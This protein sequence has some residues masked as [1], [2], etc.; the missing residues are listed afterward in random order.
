MYY[1]CLEDFARSMLLGMVAIRHRVNCKYKLVYVHKSQ[2]V[3]KASYWDVDSS[4][5]T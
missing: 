2:V 3:R 1:E 4:L 5:T